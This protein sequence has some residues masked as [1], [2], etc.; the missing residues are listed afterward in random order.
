MSKLY[1]MTGLSGSGK[2]T[3]AKEFAKRHNLL[4]LNPDNFYNIVNNDDTEKGH[5][6]EFQV[7]MMLWQAI[8]CAEISNKNIIID[9]NAPTPCKREQFL[10]WFNFDENHLI[11]ISTNIHTCIK[12]NI[13]RKRQIPEDI[14][15]K[16][17]QEYQIPHTSEIAKRWDTFSIYENKDNCYNFKLKSIYDRKTKNLIKF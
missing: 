14:F 9:T 16:M 12:N 2:T 8:H 4:S 3:F 15:I 13:Y 7:W 6:H 1:L 11:Y 17:C 10:D 5:Q